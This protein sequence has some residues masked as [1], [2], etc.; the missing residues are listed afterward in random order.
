VIGIKI[1]LTLLDPVLNAA[2]GG[3]APASDVTAPASNAATTAR[4]STG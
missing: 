3:S 1:E 4:P 2:A